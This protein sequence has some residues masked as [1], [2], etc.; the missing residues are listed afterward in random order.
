MAG[1]QFEGEMRPPVS[2]GS[3][4]HL[5]NG[6]ASVSPA[7]QKAYYRLRA[8]KAE[9]AK[10]HAASQLLRHAGLTKAEEQ[11]GLEAVDAAFQRV[12]DAEFKLLQTP[13]ET[14]RDFAIKVMIVADDEFASHAMLDFITQEA[15][16]LAKVET[17]GSA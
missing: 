2:S 16:V 6:D 13:A 14:L 1:H 17:I 11:L 12:V 5:R 3:S 4:G 10:T 15:R 7:V 9:Y 8:V